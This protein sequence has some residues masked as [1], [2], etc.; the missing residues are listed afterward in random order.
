MH[1]MTSNAIEGGTRATQYLSFT[2]GGLEYGLDFAKVQEL[3]V[4]KALERF[5][6]S[7]EI[8]GGVAVSRGVI[9]P[10]VDMRAAFGSTPHAPDPMTDVIIL[11][12][13]SCVMGMVVDGVTGVVTLHPD[14]IAP[15]PGT[16]CIDADY[17]IGIAQKGERRLIL[18]DIDR[19]MSVRK[20]GARQV[21]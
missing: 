4:L 2:L 13:T 3:R 12:L 5:A 6:S 9:M 21:A 8:I 17:L 11:R 14:Q 10:L 18:V 1:D 19:L 7:G 16:D 15:V 20:D